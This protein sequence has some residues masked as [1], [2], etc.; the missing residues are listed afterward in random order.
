MLSRVRAPVEE[1]ACFEVAEPPGVEMEAWR[2]VLDQRLYVRC[3]ADLQAL[4]P[5]GLAHFHASKSD[6]C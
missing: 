4:Q 2:N 6:G 5:G 3:Q 1:A